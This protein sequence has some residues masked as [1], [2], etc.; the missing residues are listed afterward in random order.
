MSKEGAAVN[1]Q[2]DTGSSNA[3]EREMQ[4]LRVLATRLG[5]DI[6]ESALETYDVHDLQRLLAELRAQHEARPRRR[7]WPTRAPSELWLNARSLEEGT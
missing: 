5:I 3:W 2:R 1:V 4:R 6:Q 7:W